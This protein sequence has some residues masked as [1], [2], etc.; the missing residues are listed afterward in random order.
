MLIALG[1]DYT[2]FLMLK[3]RDELAAHKDARVGVKASLI[4]SVAMIG[5]VVISAAVILG[6]TFAALIPSGVLTLIQVAL[7]VIVGLVLLVIL[8]PLVLPAVISLT[9]GNTAE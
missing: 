5:T 2:I 7:V 6:G 3:Y 1:V 8:I 9:Q 4:K